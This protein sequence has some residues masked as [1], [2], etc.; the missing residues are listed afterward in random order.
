MLER[1]I[2]RQAAESH[3][4]GFV[5]AQV[6][7]DARRRATTMAVAITGM[8]PGV[9]F[10]PH[11]LFSYALLHDSSRLGAL[12]W[13]LGVNVVFLLALGLALNALL[14]N[15]RMLIILLALVMLAALADLLLGARRPLHPVVGL[16]GALCG[17]AGMHLVF[18]AARRIP[19]AAWARLGTR[20]LEYK[21]WPVAGVWLVAAWV[22]FND[23]V[24]AKFELR[25]EESVV[26]HT[27]HA[28]LFLVGGV[29]ALALLAAGQVRSAEGDLISVLRSRRRAVSS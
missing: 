9:G 24:P 16:S 15:A 28:I 22:L 10:R 13:H 14:G 29:S 18:F 8:P 11:Q 1:R 21:T 19:L 2:K 3:P 26:S 17:L 23:L 12:L 5:S 27:T 4:Q 6:E 25:G 7:R 20:R